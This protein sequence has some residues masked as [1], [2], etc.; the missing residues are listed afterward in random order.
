MKKNVRIKRIK[1]QH[2]EIG[3][4]F[5]TEYKTDVDQTSLVIIILYFIS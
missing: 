5:I 1:S 3:M 4:Q 2:H